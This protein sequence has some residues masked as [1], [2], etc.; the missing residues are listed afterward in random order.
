MLLPLH[1]RLRTSAAGRVRSGLLPGGG[2]S[3]WHRRASRPVTLWMVALI[4]VVLIH[5]W[6]PSRAG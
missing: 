6:I 2:R 1:C 5:Q 3:S 4:V